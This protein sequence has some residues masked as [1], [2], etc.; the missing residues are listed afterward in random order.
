MLRAGQV[1]Q[2]NLDKVSHSKHLPRREIRLYL[3]CHQQPAFLWNV[4]VQWYEYRVQVYRK[5]L[6]NVGALQPH[7]GLC[8]LKCAYLA[9]NVGLLASVH[10]DLIS[11]TGY[12]LNRKRG[13][14]RRKIH[15]EEQLDEEIQMLI[16]TAYTNCLYKPECKR[17]NLCLPR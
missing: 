3:K 14:R 6:D 11:Q 15:T 2:W 4:Q 5:W 17:S 7:I 10:T 12:V 1:H 16:Q 8:Y 13:K 9:N